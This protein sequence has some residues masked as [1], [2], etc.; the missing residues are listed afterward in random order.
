MRGGGRTQ[1]VTRG[2]GRKLQGGGLTDSNAGCLP[3]FTKSAD[4]YCIPG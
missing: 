1:P 2:S 4:G 3:G